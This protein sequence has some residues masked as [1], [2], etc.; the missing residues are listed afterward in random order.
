MLISRHRRQ[1]LLANALTGLCLMSVC[2]CS[3]NALTHHEP[4]HVYST[5]S[6]KML[7]AEERSKPIPVEVRYPEQAAANHAALTP[8]RI[9]HLFRVSAQ[10]D[11]FASAAEKNSE[12][13]VRLSDL[14]GG[15]RARTV[16]GSEPASRRPR[17]IAAEPRLESPRDGRPLQQTETIAPSPLAELYPDEYLFDGG[18]RSHTAGIHADVQ[19]GVETE[20]TLAGWVAPDGTRRTRASNRVAIYSPRFGSIR[21][22]SGLSADTKV[23]KAAGA[24]DSVAVG[25]LNTKRGPQQNVADVAMQG[26]ETRRRADGVINLEPPLESVGTDR[27]MQSLKADKLQ[28]SRN[29][30]AA[31]SFERRLKF[32]LAQQRQNATVWTRREFPVIYASTDSLSEV[33][34][35]FKVQETIGLEDQNKAGTLHLVKLA[36]RDAALQGEVI[37]F[38]IRY[39]NTGDIELQE[40]RV[41]DN[42]TPRL[43]YV[44]GSV[45]FDENHPGSVEDEP[46]GEGSSTL[47]FRLNQPLPGHSA[48]TITFQVKVR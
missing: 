25:S 23:D 31:Q 13:V 16:S 37:R 32:V 20:D 47:T 45:V 42:L 2:G 22:L 34:A 46:N 26:I 3:L 36:D 27:P 28:Q 39:E 11:E 4:D 14:P 12:G 10:G 18:D 35:V 40:V 48:G 5:A 38:T 8:S 15:G 7:D 44:P 43:E 24:R 9:D 1:S 6:P 33:K 30:T 17:F 19:S 29:T 41:V 21:T